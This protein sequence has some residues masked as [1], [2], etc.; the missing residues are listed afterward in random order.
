MADLLAPSGRAP[1]GPPRTDWCRSGGTDGSVMLLSRIITGWQSVGWAPEQLRS[2]VWQSPREHQRGARIRF[3]GSPGQ[4]A[5]T[6]IDARLAGRPAVTAGI[7][8]R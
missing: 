4:R 2:R 8:R 1:E 5:A 7:S 3:R 6:G